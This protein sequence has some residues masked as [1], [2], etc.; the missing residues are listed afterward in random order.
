M[1]TCSAISYTRLLLSDTTLNV[2]MERMGL[3]ESRNCQCGMGIDDEHHFLFEC[4]QA[5]VGTISSGHSVNWKKIC[6]I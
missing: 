4:P 1:F 3:A 2:H 6:C 5:T